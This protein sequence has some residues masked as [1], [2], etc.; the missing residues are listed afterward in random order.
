[1]SR[2]GREPIAVPAGVQVEIDGSRVAVAGPRG[3]LEHRLPR[4]IAAARDGMRLVLRREGESRQLRALHGLSRTLVAN[5]V[6]GVTEGFSKSL[7]LVGT[8]YRASKSGRRLV[9]SVGY[10][11]QVELDPPEGLEFDVPAAN[12]VTVR[13]IDKQA[14]GQLAAEVRAVRPP[15]AYGEGKG[16][17]YSGERVRLKQGK[18]GK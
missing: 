5:M 17:R 9:L 16:I 1:V 18:T 13:G 12:S 4:G 10:S 8:G 7:E 15:S 6:Q 3:R 14:V 2:V 11:H